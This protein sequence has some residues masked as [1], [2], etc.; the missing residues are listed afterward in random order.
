M[1]IWKKMLCTPLE[2]AWTL[3]VKDLEEMLTHFQIELQ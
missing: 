2:D 1:Y 3:N